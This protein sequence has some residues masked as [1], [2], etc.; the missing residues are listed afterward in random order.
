MFVFVPISQIRSDLVVDL[1]TEYAKSRARVN[2]WKEEVLLVKEEMRRTVAFLLWKAK[3]WESL[4][5]VRG[6]G[7]A[8]EAGLQ[9]EW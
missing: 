6:T 9:E 1:K 4:V 7:R 3:W 8:I 5:G 2:R